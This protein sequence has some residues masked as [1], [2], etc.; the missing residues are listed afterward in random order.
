MRTNA[1]ANRAKNPWPNLVEMH[2]YGIHDEAWVL[3]LLADIVLTHDILDNAINVKTTD[4]RGALYNYRLWLCYASYAF[5]F[6]EFK[7]QL[8]E[9]LGV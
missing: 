9:L 8:R 3:T 5:D 4:A 6:N 2:A 1:R 7:P